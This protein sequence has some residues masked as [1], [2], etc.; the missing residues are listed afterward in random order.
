VLVLFLVILHAEDD[1][2]GPGLAARVV[3]VLVS[4]AAVAATAIAAALAVPV[5]AAAVT[6]AVAVTAAGVAAL[7]LAHHLVYRILH[8]GLQ[9]LLRAACACGATGHNWQGVGPGEG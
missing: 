7:Q 9:I 6:I 1:A 3:L 5:A 2:W 8:G 4:V